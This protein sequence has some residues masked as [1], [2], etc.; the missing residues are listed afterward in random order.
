MRSMRAWGSVDTSLWM[1]T[2][3]TQDILHIYVTVDWSLSKFLLKK[4]RLRIHTTQPAESDYLL[5]TV[6]KYFSLSRM[7][8]AGS[9][10]KSVSAF[11]ASKPKSPISSPASVIR[12]SHMRSPSYVATH[13]RKA[14]GNDVIPMHELDDHIKFKEELQRQMINQLRFITRQKTSVKRI[15]SCSIGL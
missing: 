7:N 4:N 1:R 10:T 13:A 9:L 5:F 2:R 15:T 14:S 8:Q 11:T 6:N 12:P 3:H